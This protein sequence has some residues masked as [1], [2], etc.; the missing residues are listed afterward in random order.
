MEKREKKTK[1]DGAKLA[2]PW[3]ESGVGEESE[4]EGKGRI[5]HVHVT[6]DYF[7]FSFFSSPLLALLH[8]ISSADAFAAWVGWTDWTFGDTFWDAFISWLFAW[9]RVRVP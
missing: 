3:V 9:Q 2:H 1:K 4:R 8:Q 7:I 6:P 5:S